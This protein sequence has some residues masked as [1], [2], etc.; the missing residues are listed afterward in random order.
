MTNYALQWHIPPSNLHLEH[1][2]VHVWLAHLVQEPLTIGNLYSLL[3]E[4]EQ[5]RAAKF[6]FERDRQRYIIAHGILHILLGRYLGCDPHAIRFRTNNY[7]KPSL[8]LTQH[9]HSLR[10]NLS[11]SHEMALLAFAYDRELG[12]DIEYMRDIEDYDRLARVSFSPN[13]RQVLRELDN[14][15]KRQGFYNCW[16][17]K[18]AYIKARGMGLSLPL[19]LF[20]VSLLSGEPAQLLASREDA[21]EVER[22]SMRDLSPAPD[23]AGALC[24]EDDGWKLSCYVWSEI[25]W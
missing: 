4:D 17:R 18:E 11:H 15:E 24:V 6:Y 12:V 13:E 10:F 14:D 22:W 23:Y 20:D 3:S 8:D 2:V 9:E 1:N 16:T 21:R 19:N 25:S 5:V 7:G